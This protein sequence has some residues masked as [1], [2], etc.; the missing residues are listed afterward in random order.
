M[1]LMCN[2]RPAG[3]DK[4]PP[5][6]PSPSPMMAW[7]LCVPASPVPALALRPTSPREGGRGKWGA[8]SS[9]WRVQG[10]KHRG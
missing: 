9:A 1:V 2:S 7:D 4:T 8:G 5:Q 6:G 3:E 10:S